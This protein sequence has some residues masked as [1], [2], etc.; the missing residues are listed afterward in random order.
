[1]PVLKEQLIIEVRGST[2]MSSIGLTRLGFIFIR[3]RGMGEFQRVIKRKNF[4][5]SGGID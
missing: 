2:M 4:I 3:S 5:S 1:M